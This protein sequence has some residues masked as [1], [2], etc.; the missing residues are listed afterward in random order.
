MNSTNRLAEQWAR[1]GEGVKN[2]KTLYD[3]AKSPCLNVSMTLIFCAGHLIYRFGHF[4]LAD[5]PYPPLTAVVMKTLCRI[6]T[7]AGNQKWE[8]ATF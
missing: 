2:V 6:M 7:A 5:S 1:F 4:S 8:L 3:M